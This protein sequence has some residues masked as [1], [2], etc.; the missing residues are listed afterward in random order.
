M[1]AR[2]IGVMGGTFDPIHHGHLVAAEGARHRYGL[3]RVL[4]VPAACSPHKAGQAVTPGHHRLAMALLATVSNPW[5]DVSAL[6]LERPAPSYTIDTLR[7]L[8]AALGPETELYF[9]TGADAILEILRWRDP[10]ALLRAARFVAATRPGYAPERL[11][12]VTARLPADLRGRVEYL[13]VPAL[14][15]SSTDLRRRVREGMPIRYLVPEP[16][17]HYIRKNGL[18]A[19]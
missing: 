19:T 4:F 13:E 1:A 6:E 8:Q 11:E 16:V 7:A 3:E 14:A 2:R 5:F 10:E 18:Y 15:I 12:A 9:I 17:E